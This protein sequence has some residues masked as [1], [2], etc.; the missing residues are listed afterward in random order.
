VK[1]VRPRAATDHL[2]GSMRMM[3]GRMVL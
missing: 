3:L 2:L 1:G